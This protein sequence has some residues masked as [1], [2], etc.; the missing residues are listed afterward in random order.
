M[1][2]LQRADRIAGPFEVYLLDGDRFV[3]VDASNR[4]VLLNMKTG[5]TTW[6]ASDGTGEDRR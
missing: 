1:E 4:S 3:R 2:S 5:E 6:M